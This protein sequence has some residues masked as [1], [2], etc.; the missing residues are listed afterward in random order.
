M[1]PVDFVKKQPPPWD[2][3]GTFASQFNDRLEEV[4][5]DDLTDSNMSTRKRMAAIQ[6][7]E[8]TA[9]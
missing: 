6:L 5:L 7:K 3:L 2:T 1:K 4:H 8:I 9:Y